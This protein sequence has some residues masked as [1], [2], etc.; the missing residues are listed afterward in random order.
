L[1]YVLITPARNEQDFLEL[2]IQSMLRQTVR[3]L[4][5]VVVSDGS[6]DRTDE[7]ASAYAQQH[8]WIQFVRMPE[9][10]GRHFGGKVSSFNAGMASVAALSFEVLGN[11]DADLSFDETYF[12]FLLHKFE[13]DSRLGVAGTPFSENGCTYDYRFSSANHVSGACQL[14]R[15]ECFEQIGGYVPLPGGGIDD[16]A[17]VSARMRGWRTQTFLDK[18][19]TH[20]RPMGT[21]NTRTRLSVSFQSGQRAYRLGWHP[22]WQ[23]F[24]SVY[25]MTR[26]PYITG[27]AALLFGYAY[28][29]IRRVERPVTREVCEYQRRDQ[30]RRLRA[31]FGL[32]KV[33]TAQSQTL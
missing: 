8:P 10:S 28:A 25:Q 33:S 1:R 3:P 19:I 24:R 14:F 29:F 21:G 4:R 15:R 12:E 5:W 32:S 7:I 17:V 2:T 16:L 27:G 18:S 22:L 20:H 26:K 11:L 23:L 6:T 9:R 30:M 31:F 13:E